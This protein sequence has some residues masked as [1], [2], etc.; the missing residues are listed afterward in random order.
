VLPH[1][2]GV[3]RA[4]FSPDGRRLVTASLDRTARIWTIVTGDGTPA[5]AVLLADLAELAGGFRLSE[6]GTAVPLDQQEVDRRRS[7]LRQ[8]R[9]SEAE[10]LSLIQRLVPDTARE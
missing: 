6:R 10:L 7:V 9:S 3:Y 2:Y 8:A 5:T 4:R 1:R